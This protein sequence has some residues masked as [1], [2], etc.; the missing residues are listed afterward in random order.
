MKKADIA[1][2][3]LIGRRSSRNSSARSLR[4]PAGSSLLTPGGLPTLTSAWRTRLRS[5]SA[6]PM[7]ARVLPGERFA[8][9]WKGGHGDLDFLHPRGIGPVL[10]PGLAVAARPL[11]GFHQSQVRALVPAILV[12]N[13]QVV[14]G[15]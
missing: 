6:D 4:S 11:E 14:A 12:K 13:P 2:K 5:A 9:E 7:D 15:G 8:A 3:D 1:L 10:T